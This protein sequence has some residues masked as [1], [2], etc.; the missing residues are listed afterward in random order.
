MT[1]RF[2]RLRRVATAQRKMADACDARIARLT[3]EAEQ[4]KS[5]EAQALE[6]FGSEPYLQSPLQ[7]ALSR[8]VATLAARSVENAA[9][10]RFERERKTVIERRLRAAERLAGR[11][12]DDYR[13]RNERGEL[14]EAT[15][16]DVVR[17]SQASQVKSRTRGG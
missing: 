5:R 6:S 1:A 9:E 12:E 15:L 14:E 2:D 16:S 13:I 7:S 17:L 3:L 10:L 8:S 4:L 11:L